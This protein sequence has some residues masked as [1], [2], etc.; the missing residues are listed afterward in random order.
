MYLPQVEPQ[1]PARDPSVRG[2]MVDGVSDERLGGGAGD[3]WGGRLV[4][5][6]VADDGSLM[7]A[8]QL[9]GE[10]VRVVDTGSDK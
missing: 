5:D 4:G 9:Y 8:Q 1:P 3:G 2:G 7:Q 10:V 6:G